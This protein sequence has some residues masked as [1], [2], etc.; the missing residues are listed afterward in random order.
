MRT[1]NAGKDADKLDHSYTANGNL[2]GIVTPENSL[3]VFQ[4][5]KCRTIIWPS[6]FIP[7]RLSQKNENYVHIKNLCS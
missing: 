3:I 2:N 6:S 7:E 1:P 4:K 5:P